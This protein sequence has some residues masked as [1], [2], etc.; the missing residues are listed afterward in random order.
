MRWIRFALLVTFWPIFLSEIAASVWLLYRGRW[1]D[2]I[3]MIALA[4]WMYAL[5]TPV[6]P[7]T[8]ITTTPRT[9]S[10]R[11]LKDKP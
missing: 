1:A 6:A 10:I 5:K 2:A 3:M 11:A 9:R 7:I 8:T 4:L